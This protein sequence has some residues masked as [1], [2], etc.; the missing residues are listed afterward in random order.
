MD[1]MGVVVGL[2]VQVGVVLIGAIVGLMV[3]VVVLMLQ[4][5]AFVVGLESG[6]RPWRS[7]I[8]IL[9]CFCYKLKLA[10]MKKSNRIGKR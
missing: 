4:C 3:A 1:L 5:V 2:M 10:G 6:A 9:L 8:L 7:P